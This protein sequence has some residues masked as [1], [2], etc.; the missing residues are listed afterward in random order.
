[1]A[2]KAVIDLVLLGILIV[3]VWSGYKKGIIMGIGGILCIIVAVYGANLLANSF[4]YELRPNIEPNN[5]TA[6]GDLKTFFEM[7]PGDCESLIVLTVFP[8][9]SVAAKITLGG[10]LR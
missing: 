3:C 6:S 9:K 1:M 8:D 10:T 5:T 4:S 2:M 7:L